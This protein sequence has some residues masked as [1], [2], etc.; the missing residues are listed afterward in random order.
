[1]N[2]YFITDR[3]K[4]DSTLMHLQDIFEFHEVK[5]EYS[6]LENIRFSKWSSK[7]VILI[8]QIINGDPATQ[9]IDQITSY[10]KH[11]SIYM[12]SSKK[13]TDEEE[14]TINKNKIS[15]FS[16]PINENEIFNRIIN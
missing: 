8:D 7:K 1:M 6:S 13:F 16:L 10:N 14:T 15:I 12:F 11:S 9:V 3:K 5:I 2:I 4:N